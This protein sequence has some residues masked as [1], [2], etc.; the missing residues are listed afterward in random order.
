MHLDIPSALY[1]ILH[2]H[3]AGHGEGDVDPRGVQD[4]SSVLVLAFVVIAEEGGL[5]LGYAARQVFPHA[6]VLAG[7][8]VV[9]ADVP[10]SD[11]L[12]EQAR[13]RAPLTGVIFTLCPPQN[14]T[15]LCGMATSYLVYPR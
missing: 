7:P 11:V 4:F 10:R 6:P 2:V 9:V 15:F 1:P 13:P 3:A 8:P 5:R 12:D 14:V